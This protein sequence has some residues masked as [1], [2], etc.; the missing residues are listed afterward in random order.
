MAYFAWFMFLWDGW[1]IEYQILLLRCKEPRVG[2]LGNVG[3][4]ECIYVSTV[5][6]FG[7]G[8]GAGLGGTL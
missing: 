8:L 7:S 4:V 6:L 2:I 1:D 3:A 5:L